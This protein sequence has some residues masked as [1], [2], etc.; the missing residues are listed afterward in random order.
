MNKK[1]SEKL[2]LKNLK[3]DVEN[4]RIIIEQPKDILPYYKKNINPLI[5]RFN[6]A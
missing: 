5:D 6:R 3:I 2:L 1:K 4:N